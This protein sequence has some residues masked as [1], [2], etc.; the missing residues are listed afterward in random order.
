MMEQSEILDWL[1]NYP[2]DTKIAIG[3][4]GLALVVVGTNEEEYCEVGGEPLPEDDE[5]E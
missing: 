4:G 1:K 5:E 3:E 2:A